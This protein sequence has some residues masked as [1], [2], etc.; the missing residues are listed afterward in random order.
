MKLETVTIKDLDA[1]IRLQRW[2]TSTDD[3][4]VRLFRIAGGG[5]DW[6]KHLHDPQ[7][8]TAT[9]IWDFFELHGGRVV[10]GESQRDV[11]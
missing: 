2:S 1:R 6:P 10:D 3:T 4:E 5:H 9:E 8:S 7:R 11:R